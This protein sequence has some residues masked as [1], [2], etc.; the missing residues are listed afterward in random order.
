MAA[1]L[2]SRCGCAA[3]FGIN[4]LLSTIGRPSRQQKCSA[5][6]PLCRAC[7]GKLISDLRTLS[8]ASLGERVN[9]AYTAI[10]SPSQDRSHPASYAYADAQPETSESPLVV[11][12]ADCCRQHLSACK[13]CNCEA[14]KPGANQL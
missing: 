3:D 4:V 9:E 11:N 1:K 13:S 12:S 7:L 10:A 14:G 6:S 2:C 5:S 8:S